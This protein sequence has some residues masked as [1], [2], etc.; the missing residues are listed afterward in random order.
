M[1]GEEP[2]RPWSLRHWGK[3]ETIFSANQEY[4]MVRPQKAKKRERRYKRGRDTFYEREPWLGSDPGEWEASERDREPVVTKYQC[5]AGGARRS[6]FAVAEAK[7][8][9][10]DGIMSPVTLIRIWIIRRAQARLGCAIKVMG[11][12][13]ANWRQAALVRAVG[14]T[15]Y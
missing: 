13:A 1:A 7:W 9:G 15:Q 14:I 6:K 11:N 2:E 12:D 8:K 10:G 4:S 5:A 3:E